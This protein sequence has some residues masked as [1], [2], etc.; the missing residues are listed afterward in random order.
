M[1]LEKRLQRQKHLSMCAFYKKKRIDA[2]L[3]SLQGRARK[4]TNLPYFLTS[5]ENTIG[6]YI[7]HWLFYIIIMVFKARPTSHLFYE[8]MVF[9]R[10]KRL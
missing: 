2:R 4:E 8:T 1:A 6:V 5:I 10:P 9:K 3:H 7:I